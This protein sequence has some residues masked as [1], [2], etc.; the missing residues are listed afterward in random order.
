MQAITMA[1]DG[2]RDRIRGVLAARRGFQAE[3]ES[4]RRL[5]PD[6]IVVP[7]R[8]AHN[9]EKVMSK[10]YRSVRHRTNG[11]RFIYQGLLVI[12]ALEV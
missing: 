11:T 6:D 2:T 1:N 5:F 10:K 3:P 8:A 12:D 7:A 4:A 9:D